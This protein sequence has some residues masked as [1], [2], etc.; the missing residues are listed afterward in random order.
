MERSSENHAKIEKEW[1]EMEK[2]SLELKSKLK[3]ERRSPKASKL[4]WKRESSPKNEF[5]SSSLNV[6]F[7]F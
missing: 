5:F 1:K 7:C 4:E 3:I 2:C 6:L